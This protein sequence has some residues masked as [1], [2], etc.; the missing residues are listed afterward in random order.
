[1]LK[2]KPV[3]ITPQKLTEHPAQAVVTHSEN[4]VNGSDSNADIDDNF[5]EVSTFSTNRSINCFIAYYKL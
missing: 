3:K 2:P 1:M 4:Y 5:T